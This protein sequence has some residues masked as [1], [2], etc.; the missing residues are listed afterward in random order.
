MIIT[1]REG[2]FSGDKKTV[3]ES[4]HLQNNGNLE[5]NPGNIVMSNCVIESSEGSKIIFRTEENTKNIL[6]NNIAYENFETFENSRLDQNIILSNILHR[7]VTATGET[8]KEF[9]PVQIM[10][11]NIA[12]QYYGNLPRSN[13]TLYTDV[14]QSTDIEE[15]PLLCLESEKCISFDYNILSGDCGISAFLAGDTGGLDR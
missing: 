12:L 3:L 10:N 7:G 1:S 14:V 5:T 11:E 2:F 13:Q 6:R 4:V 8:K 9:F 15:R